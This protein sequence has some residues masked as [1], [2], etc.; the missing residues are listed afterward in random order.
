MNL[1]GLEARCQVSVEPRL[2]ADT[3]ALNGVEVQGEG[4]LR[5]SAFL[6]H[7]R[8]LAGIKAYFR[9]ESSTNFPTAAGLASSA[10]GYAAISLAVSAACGLNL[11]EAGLSRLARLGSGSACRSV[12]GGFVEWMAGDDHETSYATSFAPPEHW[13]MHDHIALVSEAG[14][15]VSSRRGHVLAS[16][17]PL[18]AGRLKGVNERLERCR[19]ALFSRDFPALAEVVEADN[20]LMHAVMMTSTP[21]LIYW[22]PATLRILKWVQEWREQGIQVC[23][24][25]DAGPN[26][27]VLCP[28]EWSEQVTDLL[29]QAPEVSRIL[30]AKP[31]GPARREG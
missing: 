13:D 19:Q 24:T 2:E 25:V 29:R 28:A 18:Q 10:A 14:K 15:A 17:S 20:L 12:P 8:R 27:H 31:G 3:L 22:A 21:P 4:L 1:D 7:V 9:V 11:D 6:E 5:L 30:S 26:V 23:A 16:S